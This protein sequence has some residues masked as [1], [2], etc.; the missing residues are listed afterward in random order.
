METQEDLSNE[1]ALAKKVLRKVVKVCLSLLIGVRADS[2]MK[3]SAN[4]CEQEQYLMQIRGEGLADEEGEGAE[5]QSK[6]VYVLHP[7]CPVEDIV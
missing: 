5:S 4:V 7:N 1:R 3:A 6:T 2:W